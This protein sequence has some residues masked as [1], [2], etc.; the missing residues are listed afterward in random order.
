MK[1]MKK[2]PSSLVRMLA[3]AAAG[4]AS[5]DAAHAQIFITDNDG[6]EIGEYTAS[7]QPVNADFI[8]TDF[9]TGLAFAGGNLYVADDVDGTVTGY[10]AVTGAAI[11]S[12][13]VSGFSEGQLQGLAGAGSSLYVVNNGNGLGS[14]DGSIGLYSTNGGTGNASFIT[15]LVGPEDVALSGNL[16][17]V[18]SSAGTIGEYNATTG[19][20]INASLITG[21]NN[22]NGMVVSGNSL[23]FTQGGNGGYYSGSLSAFNLGTNTESTLA[24]SLELP[25]GLALTASNDLLVSSTYYG[26]DSVAEYSLSGA[27]V[28]ANYITGVDGVRDVVIEAPEPSSYAMLFLGVGVLVLRFR[29]LA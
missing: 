18:S 15:G 28:T 10:N 1:T 29:R 21:L 5:L 14:P 3:L 20:A 9:A 24:G 27:K 4:I 16:L 22:P 19:Q 26:T 13:L 12:P 7:G 17:F 6:G 8:S 23:Y 2:N 11:G 25:N